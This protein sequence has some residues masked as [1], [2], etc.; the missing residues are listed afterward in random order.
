MACK[1]KIK[2]N[3][4]IIK[5]TLQHIIYSTNQVTVRKIT[6][7]QPATFNSECVKLS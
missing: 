1:S 4:I 3:I 2:L 7:V 5:I 6:D